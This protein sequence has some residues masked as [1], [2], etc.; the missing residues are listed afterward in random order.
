MII[1]AIWPFRLPCPH[2]RSMVSRY[3]FIKGCISRRALARVLS[4]FLCILF[5]TIHPFSQL[6]GSLAFLVL[7]LKELV[8]SVQED[9]AQQLEITVLN[10]TGALT[11]IGISTFA[12]YLATLPRQGSVTS[13]LI[14]AVFL[15]AIGFFAGWAKSRLPRLHLSARISCF[16]S[17]FLLT[18]NIGIRSAVLTDSGGFLWMTLTAATVCLFSSVL[19]LHWSSTHLIEEVAS[20]LRILRQCLSVSMDHPFTCPS[21]Q[22]I[23]DLK[24]LHVQL[25]HRSVIL[26]EMYYRAAFELRIGRVGVKSLKPLLGIIEH[27]RR[28]LSWGMIPRPVQ[29]DWSSKSQ[30]ASSPSFEASSIELGKIIMSSFK[31]VEDL[32]IGVYTHASLRR[33]SL[34]AER[35]AVT[36]AA[37]NLNLAWHT[38]KSELHNFIQTLSEESGSPSGSVPS[39]LHHQCLFA[40]SLLQMAYDTSHILQVAQNIAVHHE[41]SPLRFW[42]PRLTWQWL[43]VAPRTFIMDEHGTHIAHDVTEAETTLSAEE[44]RQGIAFVDQQ[45]EEKSQ[46]VSYP[47]TLKEIPTGPQLSSKSL[48]QCLLS[49]PRRLWN[50][51]VVL[52]LRLRASKIIRNTQHSSHLRHAMKNAIGVAMLSFPA[53]LP[54]NSAGFQWF[55]RIHGQWMII[56]YVWVLETNTGATWRVGYLRLSGTILGAIY[57]Y[58]TWVICKRNSIGI[59]VMVTFFDI[60]I[61]WLV[62]KSS[63][64]SLGVV[65]SITLPPVVLSQYLS[66]DSSV[67]T[68]NLAWMRASTIALGI[69]TALAMN[70]LVFPRHSRVL[71]LK[72]TSRT[73]SLISQ[74]YLLLGQ[75]MFRNIYAFTPHDKQEAMKLELQIRNALHRSSSLL[76]IINDELSLVPKPMRHYREVVLKIQ[77]ILDLMTGL[78]KIQENIPRKETVVSVLKERR[79]FISCVCLSLFA[80]EH[81]FR[82]RQPLPQFLPSA[83]QALETLESQIEASMRRATDEDESVKGISLAYSVA[84]REV[85]RDM[86]GTIEELLELC[87]QLFGTSAWLTR[88]WPEM[89]V[90]NA[91]EGPGTLGDGWFGTV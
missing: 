56:S 79:E 73:L 81:V 19:T 47:P 12:K 40:T 77:K 37:I 55:S 66:P 72:Q 80:S 51:S 9:L 88:T 75:G 16:I 59:V 76:T 90:H 10:I 74:L 62:T 8:F 21:S 39:H 45:D 31:A 78:R 46:E 49:T 17:V 11:G 15:V 26:N 18:E 48:P 22:Q 29:T 3:E 53:F 43:G 60:P 67:S 6:G 91:E 82:A 35:D 52:Q 70:S 33:K 14:P 58:I 34:R 32:V 54:S 68:Q 64:P 61:T 57:A 84:E 7:S 89:S 36:A 2:S 63:I 27:L 69:I 87:R 65:A 86:V 30:P 1:S 20:T 38:A 85:M 28:E 50:H 42:L 41:A 13:R 25:V 71:F 44:V 4:T 83:R 23:A 5:V 24:D